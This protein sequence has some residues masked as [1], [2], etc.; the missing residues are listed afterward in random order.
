[1]HAVEIQDQYDVRL[2]SELSCVRCTVLHNLHHNA[3]AG[4]IGRTY[5]NAPIYGRYITRLVVFTLN[6]MIVGKKVTG[7]KE[8]G[9][10]KQEKKLQ[11]K[12]LQEKK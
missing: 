7:K 6:E 9:K 10:K 3:Q 8:T 1:M 5:T 2:S 12:K 11:E 4:H